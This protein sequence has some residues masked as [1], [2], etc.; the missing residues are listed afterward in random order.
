MLS[1]KPIYFEFPVFQGSG[2]VTEARAGL[3]QTHFYSKKS[4]SLSS[5]VTKPKNEFKLSNPSID[6]SEASELSNDF[7]LSLPFILLITVGQ[8][9][10]VA[11]YSPV[12]NEES[13]AL[14]NV[15]GDKTDKP[16]SVTPVDDEQ[17][18]PSTT[19]YLDGMTHSDSPPGLLPRFSSWSLCCIGRA[20]DYVPTKGN[21]S[22]ERESR[23]KKKTFFTIRPSTTWIFDESKSSHSMGY[24]STYES[25]ICY[26]CWSSQCCAISSATSNYRS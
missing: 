7:S 4:L 2:P 23:L 12:P 21:N 22:P 14:D 24:Q 17:P 13:D 5:L 15:T 26:K 25:N 16:K 10:S 11:L 1:I 20:S 8:S 9:K 6:L 3:F 18:I 19:E